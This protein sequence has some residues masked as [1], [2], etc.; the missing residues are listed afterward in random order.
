MGAVVATAAIALVAGTLSPA[1][2]DAAAPPLPTAD[3]FYTYD[4]GSLADQPPGAVLG[5][6]R[7]VDISMMSLL[8]PAP[9]SGTQ[10][11]YRTTDELGNPSQTVTTVFEPS[12]T[13]KGIVDYLSYYDGLGPACSPS[14]TMQG[15]GAGI[16]QEG[17]AIS[18][19]VNAGYT[20]TVPD[21]EGEDLHW[22]AGHE[23]GKSA[24]DAIRAT[25]AYL[26]AAPA[27][28]EV[29]MVGY[30]G[31]SIAGE[32][33]SELAPSYAPEL[34]LIGTAIG[35]IPVDLG[36]ILSYV[37]GTQ[38]W[39]GVIPAAL[40]SLGRAFDVDFTPYLSPAGVTA[41]QDVAD[42]CILDFTKSQA[43][44][45]ISDLVKPEYA[46]FLHIPVVADILKK[47]TMGTA[48]TPRIP[49][50]MVNGNSDGTGDGIMIAADVKGLA[51]QYCKAGDTVQYD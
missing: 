1:R 12:G 7:T 19:L 13:S 15:G 34:D 45:T 39:A 21:F 16:G 36:H 6:P 49:M 35:G 32:W 33:A 30:S 31:G 24:L 42:G 9:T 4:G 28:T 8:G 41:T 44:V 2:A 40:V 48:G 26:G 10:L 37:D 20:V 38:D 5:G 27:T 47:L 51:T 43:G 14:Y 18:M 17:I 11:L 25:E 46:D 3:P 22:A 50:L 29:A 23:S